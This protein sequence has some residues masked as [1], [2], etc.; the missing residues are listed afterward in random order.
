[1]SSPQRITA[2]V[3]DRLDAVIRSAAASD[4]DQAADPITIAQETVQGHPAQ[5]LLDG[6]SRATIVEAR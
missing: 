6:R 3:N 5:V 1:M 2:A 4:P